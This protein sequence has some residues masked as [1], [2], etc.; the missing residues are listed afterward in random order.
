M[1]ITLREHLGRVSIW[2]IKT[3]LPLKLLPV[4]LSQRNKT[5]LKKALLSMSHTLAFNVLG[6]GLFFILSHTQSPR[7]STI[8]IGCL[9]WM[10]ASF[11]E[12]KENLTGIFNWRL[13]DTL[14]I[15]G[16][17]SVIK[18]FT[19]TNAFAIPILFATAIGILNQ[20]YGNAKSQDDNTT[21]KILNLFFPKDGPPRGIIET[22]FLKIFRLKTD[23]VRVIDIPFGFFLNSILGYLLQ[24][25]FAILTTVLTQGISNIRGALSKSRG[26]S[27]QFG[28]FLG[29]MSALGRFGRVLSRDVIQNKSRASEINY[30][31]G[32]VSGLAIHLWPSVFI[33]C[34]TLGT[35]FNIVLKN[36][37]ESLEVKEPNWLYPVLHG[38]QMAVQLYALESKD[39][40]LLLREGPFAPRSALAILAGHK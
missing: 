33:T 38:L 13:M 28:L 7:K 11:V 14:Y 10:T 31:V 21:Y 6:S 17:L 1:E 32:F 30:F 25:I 2:A 8:S 24:Q 19:K 20:E 29:V 15:L 9:A 18:G 4:L 5:A 27:I 35:S 36:V 23:K 12:T 37:L 26:N 22:F 34:V 39:S 3:Y 16:M 40:Q